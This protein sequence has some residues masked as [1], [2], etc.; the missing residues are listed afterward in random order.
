MFTPNELSVL[1]DFREKR[2]REWKS[3]P[4]WQKALFSIIGALLLIG[5]AILAIY[6]FVWV[7]LALLILAPIGYLW[8]RWRFRKPKTPAARIR[9]SRVDS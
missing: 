6:V 1:H 2:R 8:F 3:M 5:F 4:L 7:F 9:I